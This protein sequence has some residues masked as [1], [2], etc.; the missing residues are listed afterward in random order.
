[1]EMERNIFDDRM[2]VERDADP[3][4]VRAALAALVRGNP[5]VVV[6]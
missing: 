2:A 5:L 1:M 6:M 4:N 3:V